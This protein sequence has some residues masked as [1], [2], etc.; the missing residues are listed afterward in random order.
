[1]RFCHS[2]SE[3]RLAAVLVADPVLLKA[4]NFPR[5]HG[6]KTWEGA[7]IGLQPCSVVVPVAK[8]ISIGPQSRPRGEGGGEVT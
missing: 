5:P 4:L 8:K 1:M 3:D 6:A 2:H 7:S